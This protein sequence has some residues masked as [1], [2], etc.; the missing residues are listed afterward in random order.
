V[1][2][3]VEALEGA[4]NTIEDISDVRRVDRP[5]ARLIPPVETAAWSS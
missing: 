1:K 4:M 3:I 5:Q 2:D